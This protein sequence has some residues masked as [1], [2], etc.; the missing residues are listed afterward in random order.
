M[1]QPAH[2][3]GEG[4]IL[5]PQPTENA[6]VVENDLAVRPFLAEPL[7]NSLQPGQPVVGDVR[8]NQGEVEGAGEIKGCFQFRPAWHEVLAELV[9]EVEAAEVLVAVPQLVGLGDENSVFHA[10]LTEG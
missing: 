8:R 10:G 2:Y 9:A 4:W 3:W 6:P 7:K 1:L 5:L